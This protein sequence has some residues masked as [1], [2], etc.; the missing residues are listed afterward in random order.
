MKKLTSAIYDKTSIS[1]YHEIDDDAKI[2]SNNIKENYNRMVFCHTPACSTGFGSQ[3]LTPAARRLQTALHP[4]KI[5][6]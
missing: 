6:R 1:S 3:A 5:I 2:N 4:Q